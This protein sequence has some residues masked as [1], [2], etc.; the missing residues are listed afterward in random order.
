MGFVVSLFLL[1]A[2]ATTTIAIERNNV[3]LVTPSQQNLLANNDAGQFLNYRNAVETYML[4]HPTFT[5]VVPSASLYGQYS[6]SFLAGAGNMVTATGTSGRII[7]S[8]ASLRAGTAQ[9][10]EKMSGGNISIGLANAAGTT[11]TSVATNA[12]L[13]PVALNTTVPGGAVV[14]V[15]QIGS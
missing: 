4:A 5:G 9:I 8:Y 11:W 13:V 10:A 1:I 12:S 7:T 15:I 2:I 14:S 6:A 3:A